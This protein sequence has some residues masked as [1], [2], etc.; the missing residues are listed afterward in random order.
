MKKCLE[1]QFGAHFYLYIVR[2]MPQEN[3]KKTQNI[4]LITSLSKYLENLS[5]DFFENYF[6]E[7]EKQINA[8]LRVY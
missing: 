7:F 4:F 1:M 8:Y 6:I 3:K 2:K 5:G